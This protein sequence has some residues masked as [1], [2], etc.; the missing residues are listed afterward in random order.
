MCAEDANR[1]ASCPHEPPESEAS[2][3]LPRSFS[4]GSFHERFHTG[5][6]PAPPDTTAPRA[7]AP[8]LHGADTPWRR[9]HSPLTHGRRAALAPTTARHSPL[10]HRRHAHDGACRPQGPCCTARPHLLARPAGSMASCTAE[11]RTKRR[12]QH[13]QNLVVVPKRDVGRYRGS[14]RPE[15]GTK[16]PGEP[17]VAPGAARCQKAK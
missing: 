17:G 8:I 13:E 3:K 7:R 16:T 4:T 1:S 11:N 14:E 10:T 5:A 12:A 6:A 15:T 9:R 2:T